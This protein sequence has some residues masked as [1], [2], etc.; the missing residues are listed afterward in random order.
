[1]KVHQR[2]IQS[3]NCQLADALKEG[4]EGSAYNSK[5]ISYLQWSESASVIQMVKCEGLQCL[6]TNGKLKKMFLRLKSHSLGLLSIKETSKSLPN[7]NKVFPTSWEGAFIIDSQ[8]NKVKQQ[9][10][11][12]L[13]TEMYLLHHSL[14]PFYILSNLK[15]HSQKKKKQKIDWIKA[16]TLSSSPP[17][18]CSWWCNGSSAGVITA[19]SKTDEQILCTGDKLHQQYS[20]SARTYLF[21]SVTGRYRWFLAGNNW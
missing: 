6:R 9:S 8:Q 19:N 1:M 13:L 10:H 2:E 18:I 7:K 12:I 21:C 17:S 3:Q 11:K 20:H 5:S 4:Q 14:L 15:I 16:K